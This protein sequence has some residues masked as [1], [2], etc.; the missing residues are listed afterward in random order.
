MAPSKAWGAAELLAATEVL[1]GEWRD[2]SDLLVRLAN[3]KH[4]VSPSARVPASTSDELLSYVA[5]NLD[6]RRVNLWE[7]RLAELG[8]SD[9]AVRFV[10]VTDDA[11]PSN[12]YQAYDRPPFV[13]VKG[14][15]DKRDSHAVAIVGSRSAS[16]QGLAAAAEISEAAV[17]AG[18]TVVSGLALG[19]DAAAHRAALTA[20]GRTIAV[21][22]TGIDR[23]YPSE[24]LELAAEISANGALVSQFRPGAPPTRSTFPMRNAVISALASASILIEA[25][26]RSGTRSEADHAV[27]QG[28]AV[29]LWKPILKDEVW[30]RRFAETPC[31]QWVRS[32][33]EV[34]DLV[35][36]G[37]P[38]F[39][40]A[41]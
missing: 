9:P 21:L 41:V 20:G 27:R 23:I 16:P 19:I 5:S 14:T 37:S 38:Q 40:G 32:A 30:A 22:G 34:I 6:R 31:V 1:P 15:L 3:P 36:S 8:N 4:E 29:G 12:L 28:R 39:T 35:T 11:F 13:F 2:L 33:D 24:H 26:E 10:Q 7:H 17:A 25:K 18:V